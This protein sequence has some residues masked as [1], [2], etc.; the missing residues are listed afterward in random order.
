MKSRVYFY[1]AFRIAL[2]TFVAA[3]A[4]WFFNA[5]HSLLGDTPSGYGSWDWSPQHYSI[6]GGCVALFLLSLIDAVISI[7]NMVLNHYP[8]EFK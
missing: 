1:I 5:H 4:A 6:F 2:L 7:R 3:S 8:N